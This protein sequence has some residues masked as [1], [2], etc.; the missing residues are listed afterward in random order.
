MIYT[1]NHD[2]NAW[3]GTTS[4]IFG[5]AAEAMNVL[6]FTLP[7]MPLIYSGQEVNLDRQLAF[8]EKD[9]IDWTGWEQSPAY[10][11]YEQL[12]A[13]KKNNSALGHDDQSSIEFLFDGNLDTLC[14]VRETEDNLVIV[15]VNLSDQT[16][17]ITLDFGERAGDYQSYFTNANVSIE[18]SEEFTLTPWEYL[19]YVKT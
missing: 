5:A 2:V 1:S 7:G 9:E 13:L 8:F 6:V 17:T 19:V 15:I 3:L 10:L 16:Q 18:T 12:I 11:F 4:E 14:Y